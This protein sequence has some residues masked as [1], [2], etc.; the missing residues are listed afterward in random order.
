MKK[1]PAR[2]AF[3]SCDLPTGSERR[4]DREAGEQRRDLG[5]DGLFDLDVALFTIRGEPVDDLDD[6]PADLAELGLAEATSGAGRGAETHARGHRRL[7]RVERDA[8]LVAGDMGPAERLLGGIA[9]H[10]LRAQVDQHHMG[11][12]AAGDDVEAALHQLVGERLRVQHDLLGVVL[13]LRTQ[14]FAEGHGLAG[15]DMHQRAALDAREDRRVHLLGDLF[16]VR[17]DHAAARAAQRL[18]GG[19]GD[20]IRMREGR[21]VLAA[22]H[23]AREMRHVD[24]QPGADLVRDLAEFDEVDLPRDG[25]ATGDDQLR[26]VLVGEG[27]DLVIVEPAVLLAHAI[28]DRVEPLARLV[29]ARAVGQVTA[30]VEAHAEDG[31]AGR[32]QRVEHALVRLAARVRLHVDEFAAEE[33]LGAVDCQVFGNVDE[34]AA[35]VIALA[36]VA[37][38]ILVRHHRAL[39][40]HHR[41]RDDVFRGDQL[42]LV[43]LA[44]EFVGD[45]FPDV[46]V[47]GGKAFGKEAGVALGGHGRLLN[48]MVAAR[49]SQKFRG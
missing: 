19:G 44:A 3:R 35:A 9:L 32:E 14:R 10:A 45:R 40:L 16:V 17:Q 38:G 34:L 28:L 48:G 7:F 13:E 20:H 18:V 12:G 49:L 46:G 36:R 37:L 1:A 31:V 39:G 22:G 43:A 30:G 15:D 47:A 23:E 2:G 24:H 42:D 25:R 6:Q 33:L 27:A 29:R 8:V 5:L 26:L 21:G 4:V 41:L 11:V